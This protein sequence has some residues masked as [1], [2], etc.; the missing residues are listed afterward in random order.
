[1]PNHTSTY[2]S[3]LAR[4]HR[5]TALRPPA[6]DTAPAVAE[7]DPRGYL[8]NLGGLPPRRPATQR[9]W[10]TVTIDD[11]GRLALSTAGAALGWQPG[12]PVA[13]ELGTDRLTVRATGES[14][15]TRLRSQLRLQLSQVE[16]VGLGVAPGDQVLLATDTGAGRVD[17]MPA[18]VVEAALAAVLNDG[19]Q[20][21][22]E[23][24]R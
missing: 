15:A 14:A 1:M 20:R 19:E 11:K 16:Q 18:A 8:S 3:Y 17:V 22:E 9:R 21:D 4:D 7:P 12:T 6:P 5:L 24:G 10:T 2:A 23:A 13:V